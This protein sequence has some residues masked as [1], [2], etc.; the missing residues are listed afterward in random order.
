METKQVKKVRDEVT[1]M[2]LEVVVAAFCLIIA[3][4]V[5]REVYHIN[6]AL[7]RVLGLVG[8]IA[9]LIAPVPVV[10][11][12]REKSVEP[13]LQPQPE[14]MVTK[15]HFD[16]VEKLLKDQRDGA[17]HTV[18]ELSGKVT[19]A[20]L[21]AELSRGIYVPE[22]SDIITSASPDSFEAIKLVL[23]ATDDPTNNIF[24]RN[25]VKVT[26]LVD[27]IVGKKD[28]I[29]YVW[30]KEAQL[31]FW[32]GFSFRFYFPALKQEVIVRGI[33]RNSEYC[34]EK[35]QQYAD[36]ITRCGR[37]NVSNWNIHNVDPVRA[38]W[39]SESEVRS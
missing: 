38:S 36:V 21:F 8:S 24:R 35:I 2:L 11:F 7:I 28:E 39:A 25:T 23:Q 1:Y 22:P 31:L 14:Q 12:G 33:R 30:T 18:N 20:Q 19:E 4:L 37:V 3:L 13:E 17:F 15:A 29:K 9:M 5:I 26:D 32:N 16:K 34:R 27:M 6:H 10:L